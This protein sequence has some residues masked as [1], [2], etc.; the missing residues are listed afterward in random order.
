MQLSKI[1]E[2]PKSSLVYMERY[3]N[4][5]SPSGFTEKYNT[6]D[7]TNPF[8]P[9]KSFKLLYIQ[10]NGPKV[11]IYNHGD[12][13]SLDNEPILDK[14]KNA[15]FIHPDMHNHPD[16]YNYKT[17]QSEFDV[18]PTSSSRTVHFI[19]SSSSFYLKLH[20]DGIIGRINRSL[21]FKKAISGIEISNI[22]R[23]NIDKN[24]LPNYFSFYPETAVRVLNINERNTWSFVLREDTPYKLCKSTSCIIPFFSL[25]SKDRFTAD[26]TLIHQ[27]FKNHGKNLTE[28]LVELIIKRIIE[29][30]FKLIIN[31]GFQFELNAQNVLI[32][33][34]KNFIPNSIIIRDLM[35]IEK[36]ITIRK[37]L[38]LTNDFLSSPYKFIHRDLNDN[39]YQIRHSFSYDFKVSKYIIEPLLFELEHVGGLGINVPSVIASIKQHGKKY[40]N[41]LDKDYFPENEW[42]F[43][44]N[45]LLTRERIYKSKNNPMFR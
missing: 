35:G 6:S 34:D 17:Y 43:H 15:F 30:Y 33:F 45:V 14:V 2:N 32:G 1:I 7:L 12:F 27:F 16:L 39:L 5:G 36:D 26:T 24:K 38:G 8:S 10:S 44:E 42:Y 21:P 4:N 40:I 11:Q 31:E 3:V 25:F 20:Y 29:I 41:K 28:I 22:L 9:S 23:T 13:S 37:S 19:S 18:I